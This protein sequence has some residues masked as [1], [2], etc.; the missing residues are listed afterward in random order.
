M[1]K[2]G[3]QIAEWCLSAQ[4]GQGSFATVWKASSTLTGLDVAIKV[5]SLKSLSSKLRACLKREVDALFRMRHENILELYDT[6]ELEDE[7]YLITEY[8]ANGDL[9][10]LCHAK[11]SDSFVLKMKIMRELYNGLSHLHACGY[12]HRDLKPK[13]I[14]L[15]KSGTVKIAD[16]GFARPLHSQDLA[17]TLCG[18]PIYMAPEILLH[19][20][21]GSKADMWSFG[22]VLYEMFCGR[23]PFQGA[24]CPDLLRLIKRDWDHVDYPDFLPGQ[25]AQALRH[26]LQPRP[27]R[28][29]STFDLCQYDIFEVLPISTSG[30]S[31]L[32]FEFSDSQ[33]Q[34]N[35]QLPISNDGHAKSTLDDDFVFVESEV[36]KDRIAITPDRLNQKRSS[37]L[38]SSFWTGMSPLMRRWSL[39]HRKQM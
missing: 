2:E 20:K 19:Q 6:I 29:A 4:I 3:D 9:G 31:N 25:L 10:S 28:R 5:I 27:E 26:L 39:T 12:I 1:P 13:N 18:S 16:F 36:C 21:Y 32:M 14:L 7:M 23:P 11:N 22:V 37:Q 17:E 34:D 35:A 24:N 33:L 8:C 15:D 38:L 30:S